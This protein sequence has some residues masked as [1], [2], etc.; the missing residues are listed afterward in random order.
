MRLSSE[1]TKSS[2]SIIDRIDGGLDNWSERELSREMLGDLEGLAEADFEL[3]DVRNRRLHEGWYL[4][5]PLLEAI[6]FSSGAPTIEVVLRWKFPAG[7]QIRGEKGSRNANL[8]EMG[9]ETFIL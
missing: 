3:Y 4:L 7:G 6:L 9:V 8:V 2:S 5:V 1:G